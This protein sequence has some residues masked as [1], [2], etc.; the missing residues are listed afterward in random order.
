LYDIAVRQLEYILGCNPFAMS[1]V[2][3]EGYDYPPLYSGFAGDLV[4]AVPVGIET[5][6]NDDEP[7]MPMQS[8]AT[9]KEIWSHAVGFLMECVAQTYCG[10]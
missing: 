9:Y 7:Y 10:L 3:G 2:Y 4:G 5:F 1:L 6:E 8:N